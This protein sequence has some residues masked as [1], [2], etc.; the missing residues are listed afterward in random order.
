MRRW[1]TFTQR[2]D[3][4]AGDGVASCAR[5]VPSRK[6]ARGLVP[7]AIAAGLEL[8][9]ERIADFHARQKPD[10]DPLPRRRHDA[11]TRFC[12]APLHSIG[13]YVPGGSAVAAV[14]AC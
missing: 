3:D 9:R 4:P 14:D 13:A 11:N 10:D 12:R 7:E 1:S 6:H 5:D 2:F 8:A